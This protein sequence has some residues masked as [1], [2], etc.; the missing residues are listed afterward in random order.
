LLSLGACWLYIAVYHSG[1]CQGYTFFA[2]EEAALF[3]LLLVL[4][5]VQEIRVLAP[6]KR[7][8]R[9]YFRLSIT[10]SLITLAVTLLLVVTAFESYGLILQAWSRGVTWPTL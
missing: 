7:S 1:N 3:W 5:L 2:L 10:P 6:S 4:I 9:K 8:F